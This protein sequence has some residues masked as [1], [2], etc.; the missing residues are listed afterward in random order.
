MCDVCNCRCLFASFL[1]AFL[2]RVRL[3]QMNRRNAETVR[4]MSE[5]ERNEKAA[6]SVNQEVWDNDPRYV[7]M[8]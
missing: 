7:F 4:A 6:G 1:A 2:L 8:T 5:A 3:A